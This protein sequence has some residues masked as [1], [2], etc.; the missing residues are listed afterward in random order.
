MDRHATLI[1]TL[2]VGAGN[3]SS[4]GKGVAPAAVVSSSSFLQLFPDENSSYLEN[5]IYVQNHSYGTGIET[6]YSNEA[7]V[8]DAQVN[9]IPELVH[10]FSAGNKGQETPETGNYAGI[11]GAANMTGNFKMAKNA[12]TVG[13]VDREKKVEARSSK[14]PANDGRLKP[15]LVAYAPEGTSDAAALVSGT[16]VLLQD[17]Y[18]KKEGVFPEFSLIKAVLIA[19]AEDV[20]AEHLDFSAGYGNLNAY[21]SMKI[22]EAGNYLE[23][24]IYGNG[25]EDFSITIPEGIKSFKIAISWIDPAA[26]PGDEV[27]LKNDLNLQIT[28]PSGNL[29]LPWI[30][31]KDPENLNAPAQRGKD[32]LNPSEII[33]LEDPVAGEYIIEVATENLISDVQKFSIAYTTVAED[34]FEWTFPTADDAVIRNQTP[35]YLRWK[36]SFAANSGK[37]EVNLNESGWVTLDENVDL[38]KGY[39]KWNTSDISGRAQLRM[40]IGSTEFLSDYFAV[41]QELIPE[42]VYNCEEEVLLSWESVE[43]ATAYQ[44]RNLGSFYMQ[45]F[46]EVQDTSAVINKDTFSSD[47]WSVVPIFEG[48]RGPAGFAVNYKEQGVLCY[49]QNFYALLDEGAMVNATLNLS[50]STGI[51]KITFRRDSGGEI[52]NIEEFTAPFNNLQFT[53]TDSVMEAGYSNFYVT[54]LLS[55]GREIKTNEVKIFVPGENTLEVYPNPVR[56][57]EDLTVISKGDDLEIQIFDMQGRLLSENNLI[58]YIDRF[59]IKFYTPGMYIL[60]TSR[61]GKQVGTAK[62][63]VY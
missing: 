44:L 23:G 52:S 61:G 16:A 22:I 33:T 14:G 55:D 40:T 39:Y 1:A 54:I 24:E 57:G 28:D 60:R 46:L 21:E 31:N 42:V 2:I 25:P 36:T 5:E 62:I 11:P 32:H 4:R 30:L 13:A 35:N 45:D 17:L 3:S 51:E 56:A 47:F 41:S 49:Y 9:E 26:N 15:E 63:L 20:G 7:A 10:V 29:W 50:T 6:S 38:K 18:R 27:T 59:E 43:N 19:G 34:E 58:R 37:L 53:V 12:L 8:Y 48:S